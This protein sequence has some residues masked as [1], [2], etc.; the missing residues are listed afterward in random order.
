MSFDAPL[1]LLRAGQGE[2][3]AGTVAAAGG[4]TLLSRSFR[5][6]LAGPLPPPESV[7]LGATD[8]YLYGGLQLRGLSGTLSVYAAPTTAGVATIVC[9]SGGG[10]T[11]R[12]FLT[13]CGRIAST[14][15]LLGVRTYPLGPSRGYAALLSRT[16]GRLRASARAPLAALAGARIPSTQSAAAKAV[17]AAYG[18]AADALSGATVPPMVR[19]AQAAIVAAL[20]RCAGAYG[21]VAAA[22]R[23]AAT[24]PPINATTDNNARAA[25]AAAYG[26]ASI[27]VSAAAGGLSHALRS[28]TSLGYT[29]AGQR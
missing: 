24:I 29:L 3:T 8:A 4:P 17:A 2:L 20:R 13:E 27:A 25:A 6:R 10:A 1:V 23:T 14:L 16:F 7:R 19:D 15:R 21:S 28:L 18:A 26:R 5:A 22:A 12:T 11:E 9:R